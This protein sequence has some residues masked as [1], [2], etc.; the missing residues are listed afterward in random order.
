MAVLTGYSAQKSALQRAI[1]QRAD[2]L[3]GLAVEANTVDAFQGREADLTIYSVTRSNLNR[4]IGFLA[5]DRRL[6]VALSRGKHY[7]V[8]AGDLSFARSAPGRN[9]FQNVIEY[10]ESHPTDCGVEEVR[11]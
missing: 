9:P 2:H 8:L 3:G 4:S 1:A 6:N 5:E 11:S 7:L 10:I